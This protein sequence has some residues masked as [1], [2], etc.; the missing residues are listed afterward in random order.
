[1]E[2][3]LTE[4]RINILPRETA[5]LI[6]AGEVIER[7][8][9]I[10]KEL[11]E[12]AVDA[13]ASKITVE[14]QGGGVSYIRVTDNGCGIT[15]DDVPKA[16]LRHA[17][18]KIK[19]KSD[20]TA[21]FTLG[22]RGEALA[23]VSAVSDIELFTKTRFDSFGTHFQKTSGGET[24]TEKSGCPDGT[25]IIIRD[26]FK[27]VPARLKFLKK[28]VSEGNS[29]ADIVKKTA[30]S[31]P[32][33]SFS[34]IREGENEFVTSG[35]GL[36]EAVYA[37]LGKQFAASLIPAEYEFSGVK[38]NGF[39]SS[40][41]FG[42]ANRAYQNFFINGRYVKSF[43]MLSALEEAYKNSIMTGKF[44]ACVLHLSLKPELTDVNA[45]PTKLEVKFSDDKLIYDSIYFTA[46]NALISA[47]KPAEL[48]LS[49]NA[50]DP[51]K[52]QNV[53]VSPDE[54]AVLERQSQVKMNFSLPETPKKN[55][56][57]NETDTAA[58]VYIH[59]ASANQ[60]E[61]TAKSYNQPA[62]QGDRLDAPGT[63]EISTSFKYINSSA[64]IKNEIEIEKEPE[65]L[66]KIVGEAFDT[67][68]LAERG[69]DL[70]VIDKHAAHERILFENLK[71]GS[72]KLSCQYLMNYRV[73][74]AD[75]T[76]LTAAQT[77]KETISTLGFDY[78]IESGELQLMGIPSI[79]SDEDGE[80]VFSEL[81]V[82][83]AGGSIN[84]LPKVIDDIYHT[85]ACKAAIKARDKTSVPE[86]RALANRVLSDSG[87]RFC[88]HG[89]PVVFTLKRREL[90]RNFKR[91]T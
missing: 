74:I 52:K 32:E 89:R 20:L 61:N 39:I 43:I 4:N 7:P 76:S 58:D 65:V 82:R 67:Y 6:A 30:L 41:L 68:I 28:N 81:L 16:F 14:I 42:R 69:D 86:M 54:K 31:H 72:E 70:F 59:N 24:S 1:M 44:P 26:V 87:I 15:P 60:A 18:S 45:H 21:I 49:E 57:Q 63:S 78:T 88:P 12:N 66:T 90:E 46:K 48:N 40:P 79:L 80:A 22:F 34:F 5:E 13:G 3:K 85:I 91:V 50:F 77:E 71:N 47:D 56:W 38:I 36:Y 17:T 10:V 73:I 37:V 35:G 23:S 55:A 62:S 27:N 2:N 84:P 51:Y 9:S 19:T 8:A 53:L 29:V 11:I 25:T 75:K 33:I 64:F 83:L